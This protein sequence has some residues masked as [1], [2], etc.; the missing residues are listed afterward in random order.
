MGSAHSLFNFADMGF[1][2]SLTHNSL[3]MTH[4]S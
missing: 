1:Y 4:Y 3:L 2:D